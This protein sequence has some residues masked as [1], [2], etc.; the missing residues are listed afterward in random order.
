MASVLRWRALETGGLEHLRLDEGDRVVARSVVIGSEEGEPFALRYRIECD[1]AWRVREVRLRVEG[2]G[3]LALSSDGAGRWQGGGQPL[4]ALDGCIDVDITATPFTNTLPIRRLGL[5]V[6]ENAAIRV[7]YV[8]V[9]TLALS[10]VTQHYTCLE[11]N[12]CYRYAGHPPDFS[13]E[14]QVD[15]AGLVVTYPGLFERL[16]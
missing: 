10:A 1:S 3:E 15:A 14:L 5:A 6:G 12:A 13:A 11:P 16:P 4:P 9:P 2:G 7:A 8:A